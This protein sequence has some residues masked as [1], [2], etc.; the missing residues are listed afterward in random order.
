MDGG[1]GGGGVSLAHLIAAAN[2]RLEDE[3]AAQLRPRGLS[4]EQF[5]VLESLA[6]DGEATMGALAGAVLVERPTLT[7]IV[8]RMSAAG[9]V[10]RAPDAVDRRRVH[11][12]LTEA[13]ARMV[14]D[15][16]A[17]AEAQE[18][19]IAQRLEDVGETVARKVL[20]ALA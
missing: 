18:R 19:R 3:L 8:D 16:L 9:L 4:I 1:D 2:R 14:D 12:R 6:R 13:G 11:L 17:A 20:Q 15:V 5:R 7:K 10:R